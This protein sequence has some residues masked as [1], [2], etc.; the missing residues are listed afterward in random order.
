MVQIIYL[1][2]LAGVTIDWRRLADWKSYKKK[3]KP[4]LKAIINKNI[5]QQQQ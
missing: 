5:Q 2:N 4:L 3:S 1:W